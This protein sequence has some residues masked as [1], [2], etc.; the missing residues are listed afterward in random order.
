VVVATI[1]G[2]RPGPTTDQSR[3]R[4]T[5]I[6]ERFAELRRRVL[7]YGLVPSAGTPE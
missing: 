1:S 3:D 2:R 5:P 4:G 6:G 7:L